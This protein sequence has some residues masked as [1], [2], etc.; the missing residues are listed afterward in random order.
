[1]NEQEFQIL[2]ETHY[3]ALKSYLLAICKNP[4]EA[5]DLTHEAFLRYEKH[6]PSFR[7][8]C[9][10]FTMLC[11]IGKNLWLNRKKKDKRLYPID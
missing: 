11:K 4:A 9:S 7:K 10:D 6:L 2:Y 8:K 3:R 5:E 1:M